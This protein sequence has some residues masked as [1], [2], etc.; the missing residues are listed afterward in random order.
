MPKSLLAR[1]AMPF[2]LRV[3]ER[4]ADALVHNLKERMEMA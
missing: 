4:E 3:N 2:P 1:L